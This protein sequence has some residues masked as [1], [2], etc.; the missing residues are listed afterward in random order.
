MAIKFKYGFFLDAWRGNGFHLSFGRWTFA[1]RFKWIFQFTKVP[2]KP[3]YKRLYLGPLEIEKRP[4][5]HVII[6][7]S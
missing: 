1:L 3:G 5:K 4:H 6:K 7:P 2:G